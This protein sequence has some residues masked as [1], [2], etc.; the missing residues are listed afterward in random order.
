MNVP[1]QIDRKALSRVLAMNDRQ[2]ATLVEKLVRDYGLDLSHF[3]IR[4]GDMAALRAV[5]TN[6]TDEELADMTKNLS[7]RGT[8]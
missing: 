1:L 7:R 6:A 3:H 4:E 8:R 2:L 5:L